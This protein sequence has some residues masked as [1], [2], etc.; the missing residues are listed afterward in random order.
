MFRS[1]FIILQMRMTAEEFA[2]LRDAYEITYSKLADFD[3]M[4]DAEIE[5]YLLGEIAADS[6]AG[7][8]DFAYSLSGVSEEVRGAVGE[9]VE[10]LSHFGQEQENG[11]RE[12]RG[13]NETRYSLTPYSEKQKEN[14]KNSKKIIVFENKAQIKQFVNK[15]L[16]DGGFV[17]KLYFGVI[18]GELA[19]RIIRETGYDVRGRNAALRAGNVRKIFKD[20]GTEITE[21]PRG[22]RPISPDDF[23]LI[24]DVIGEPDKIEKGEY[25]G[26]PA[27]EFKRIIDGSNVSVFAVDSG[28][29]SLDLFVQT[30]YAGIKKGSIAGMAN[31]STLTRTST[32]TA[33]TAS[34][35]SIIAETLSES[36]GVSEEKTEKIS[37]SDEHP[38]KHKQFTI[39]TG[40]NAMR[41]DIH[42]GIRSEEDIRT[43]E[44][45]LEDDGIAVGDGVTP[46][47]TA[48]MIREAKESGTITVYSSKP[49]K[50]GGFVTPSAMEARSYAGDGAIYSQEVPLSDVA[51]IDSVQGQYAPE[52]DPAES[53]RASAEV[54]SIEG[55]TERQQ[56]DIAR[57]L[58]KVGTKYASRLDT[59]ELLED[60]AELYKAVT[61]GN[62][63]LP[64]DS[65]EGMMTEARKIAEPIIDNAQERLPG[66]D[67]EKYDAIR[68]ALLQKMSIT[69]KESGD[70]PDFGLWRKS[71][72]G[73]I[74]VGIENGGISVDRVYQELSGQY[75]GLFPE[76]ELATSDK[77][78]TMLRA[79]DA[80]KPQYGNPFAADKDAAVKS[81]AEELM[82]GLLNDVKMTED[83]ADT[84]PDTEEELQR[85]YNGLKAQGL[86]Y[87]APP[88]QTARPAREISQS[89]ENELTQKGKTLI[90]SDDGTKTV[91]VD[92]T[93]NRKTGEWNYV[94]TGENVQAITGADGFATR[95]EA[96]RAALKDAD[97]AANEKSV[98]GMN[99]AYRD[100]DRERAEKRAEK[101]NYPLLKNEKGEDERAV[102]GY[103]WV[104]HN[105]RKNYGR[106]I[107]KS[108]DGQLT[109]L[110][111]NKAKGTSAVVEA[112]P[113]KLTAVQPRAEEIPTAEEV[114]PERAAVTEAEYDELTET[115]NR[116]ERD[117]AETAQ[118]IAESGMED[119]TEPD[120]SE[121]EIVSPLEEA[122]GLEPGTMDGSRERLTRKAMDNATRE[123][124]KALSEL[125]RDYPENPMELYKEKEPVTTKV[126]DKK[127]QTKVEKKKAP[128]KE[129]V[130]ENW[131]GFIR[132]MV[133]EADAVHRMA[134]ATGNESLDGFYFFAK[135]ASQRA[136]QWM[137]AQR[138]SFDMSRTGKSLNA[139]FDPIRAKGDDYYKNFQ[140]YLYS[141]LNVERMSREDGAAVAEAQRTVNEIAAADRT[142][143]TMSTEKLRRIAALH[144]AG[145]DAGTPEEARN[146]TIYQ[147]Y[148]AMKERDRLEARKNKPVFGYDVD[149][150]Q[151]K[152]E[153]NDLLQAHPEF[154]A[155]AQEVYDYC[156]DLLQYRVDAGL[157]TQEDYDNLKKIYPHYIPVAYDVEDA[158][159]AEQARRKGNVQISTTIGKAEGGDMKLMP[160]HY[161][162]ARQTL[163]VMRNSGFEQLGLEVLDE[164]RKNQATM[165]RFVKEVK[166]TPYVWESELAD[167]DDIILPNT[168]VISVLRDGRR[169]DMTLNE[170]T[171]QAFMSLQNNAS[172][173][174][175]FKG[176][177]KAIQTFKALTTAYNP[178]F[179]IT[180]PIRDVQDALFY[181]TDTMQWIKNYPQAIAEIAKNGRYWQMYKGMGGVF[182][183][184]FDFE[185]GEN[186]EKNKG[187]NAVETANMWVEQLPRLAE[188]MTV[189]KKAEKN[190]RTLTRE[191]TMNAFNAAA[192]ITTNFGRGGDLGK[193]INRNLVPFWNP[194]V[195][196]LSK[197]VRTATEQ[198]SFKAWGLMIAKAAALGMLP[199]FINGLMY[200]DDDEWDILDDDTKVN[201]YLFKGKDGVWVKIPKGRVLAMLSAPVVGT[202]EA[203]RGDDVQ[204]G[205]L[206]KTAAGSVAPNNPLETNLLS[207]AMQARLF[208]PNETGKTWYGGNIESQRLQGYRPGERYDE[209]TDIISKWIGGKLNLSPKKLSYIL[210]QYSGVIGDLVL[211]Y[212][213]P[214]A[215]RGVYVGNI[216]VPLSN[217]FM[218]SFTIDSVTSNEVS[219]DYYGLLDEMEQ[220]K[221]DKDPVSAAAYQYMSRANSEVSDYYAQIREIENDAELTDREKT[222]LTREL[223]KALVGYQQGII[224]TVGKYL[225]DAGE[226]LDVTPELNYNDSAAVKAW[227]EEYNSAQ[228]SDKNYVDAEAAAKKMKAETYREINRASLGAEAALQIYSDDVYA[229]AQKIN[230]DAEVDFEA[231]YDYYFG[232]SKLRDDVDSKGRTV[233]GSKMEKVVALIDG[234]DIDDKQKD[235]LYHD[236]GYSD[237]KLYNTPWHGGNGKFAKANK[238]WEV[239]EDENERSAWEKG[240]LRDNPELDYTA[241]AAV[242]AWMEEYN[243]AQSSD[244]YRVD[245]AGAASKMQ[246]KVE[247]DGNR[248]LYGAEY[249]LRTYSEDVY[250]AAKEL[251]DTAQLSFEDYY[252]YYF[253]SLNCFADKDENGESISGSKKEKVVALIDSLAISDDQKDALFVAAGYPS[254]TLNTAPWN[255]GSGVY[256]KS[257]KKKSGGSGS[258]GK[259]K[260]SVLKSAKVPTI[261]KRTQMQLPEGQ[262]YDFDNYDW[263]TGSVNDFYNK[264]MYQLFANASGTVRDSVDFKL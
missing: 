13:P 263:T 185:T 53:G 172:R 40:E 31:A 183:S 72:F 241:S 92:L 201:Y 76:N 108:G 210:D 249:A 9:Q 41:D 30:M 137:R 236:A 89:A 27:V 20:H 49:I 77:I 17:S 5:E 237:N 59:R 6:Y 205:Q 230:E 174:R 122:A 103:T 264:L 127:V 64:I 211:P 187:L 166:E 216:A 169:Y 221:N 119:S 57:V 147:Y 144:E 52:E 107:G 23:A 146:E 91:R 259:K 209:S 22:Q 126:T 250:E 131:H 120:L 213:T 129:R 95:E 246:S 247:R 148:T 3:A 195:Q 163:G 25:K 214:K 162:L 36:K 251:N 197:V 184:Y 26:K 188:F 240:Y 171:A 117:S 218:S 101:E 125:T 138:M 196:G 73:R 61:K 173:M 55:V 155:L 12:I 260:A 207:T 14:W 234:L 224:E 28:A 231:Y 112:D 33:G 35:D 7:M 235:A 69:K 21:K 220:A 181:S 50:A 158:E 152:L 84:M 189:I 139:I 193:W 87:Y 190:G 124:N 67:E 141:L 19:D 215:E 18:D 47:Y 175:E 118:G 140:K 191:D 113:E 199:E 45:A 110:F 198:K 176:M 178:L 186:V 164:Y 134:R 56:R 24:P 15:A 80:V 128:L 116:W 232:K 242:E 239:A 97:R 106:V 254:G 248:A 202:M 206:A 153:A 8:N 43:F 62:P 81:A 32:T 159:K 135:A 243:A 227:M 226:L 34:F 253:E 93:R 212:L 29:S 208:S 180:N 219:E 222:E 228:S 51:W 225:V 245:R 132:S 192:E 90:A 133:N 157:I 79:L 98:P 78:N 10:N 83:T 244:K 85:L 82:L 238:T 170:E 167:N 177:Q 66:W 121:Y 60:T 46:D 165:S 136:A 252:D 154:E 151:S 44:E 104:R 65:Y 156:D 255:G 38:D 100:P 102:P 115:L 233:S 149:A 58:R 203:L 258:G 42:T 204:W 54:P 4:T 168:N 150:E 39:V 179:A 161:A 217:A 130:S 145:E 94:I 262:L 105:Q 261:K 223:R 256:T 68:S 182:N 123:G 143:A 63:N 75:P 70:F 2:R 194:G 71:N 229:K 200:R 99:D 142:I 74:N 48:E 16:T 37:R 109:V 114:P 111:W 1:A 11:A 257:G 88:E 160:L 86:I 96:A